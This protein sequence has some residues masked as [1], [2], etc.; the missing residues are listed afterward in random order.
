MCQVLGNIGY[1]LGIARRSAT[2]A[3][4][5]RDGFDPAFVEGLDDPAHSFYVEGQDFGNGWT[6]PTCFRES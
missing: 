2:R 6:A 4:L 1:F 5:R 3:W